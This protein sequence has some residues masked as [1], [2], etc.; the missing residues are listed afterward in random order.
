MPRHRSLSAMRKLLGTS[1][2]DSDRV[3]DRLLDAHL[4]EEVAPAGSSCPRWSGCSPAS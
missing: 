1:P 2:L 3:V 4:V